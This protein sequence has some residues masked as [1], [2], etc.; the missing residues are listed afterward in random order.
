M[1]DRRRLVRDL[2]HLLSA[3]H[4]ASEAYA[5]LQSLPSKREDLTLLCN[6]I[7]LALRDLLVLK[8]SDK[9]PLCFF[10]DREEAEL[11]AYRRTS[12]ELLQLMENTNR[13]IDELSANANVRLTTANLAVRY[14]LL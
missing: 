14:G 7:L 1:I 4:S 12:P 11:L 8:Q 13:A 9:A 5:L 2:L 3:R 6:E 10:S